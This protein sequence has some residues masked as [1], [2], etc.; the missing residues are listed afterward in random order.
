MV[1][2]IVRHK[3]NGSIVAAI[4]VYV[5]SKAEINTDYFPY[6]KT[7]W[8]WRKTNSKKYHYLIDKFYHLDSKIG[9]DYDAYL[10]SVSPHY[11]VIF[12][13]Q[14][15][16]L[17]IKGIIIF[18]DNPQQ[19]CRDVDVVLVR[20]MT[21]AKIH[22]YRKMF[23]CEKYGGYNYAEGVLRDSG[24]INIPMRNIPFPKLKSLS[25]ETYDALYD[26]AKITLPKYLNSKQ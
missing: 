11:Q 25:S 26:V 6:K 10:K 12:K 14:M 15:V 16:N 3:T 21:D 2:H 8:F 20:L 19:F 17:F 24:G 22:L 1:K 4:P 5:P 9:S 23:C 7:R 18:M 13:S